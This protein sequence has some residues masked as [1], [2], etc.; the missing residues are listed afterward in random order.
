MLISVVIPVKNGDYWLEG[1]LEG[2]MGQTLFHRCEVILIDSGST[3]RTLEIVSRFPVRLVEIAPEQFNHG[4]TRNLGVQLAK[5][6]YVVMTVQDARAADE[7]WLQKLLDGFD[8]ADVAGVCGQQIVPHDPD[9]NPVV[10]FRPVDA[11]SVKKYRF[12]DPADFER[13]SPE[14]KRRVCSWDNVTAMYRREVLLKVPFRPAAF[15]EDAIWAKD[16]LLAGYAIVYNTAARVLHYH[17]DTPDFA[18]RRCFTTYY[19][20]HRIFGLRPSAADMGLIPLLRTMKLLLKAKSVPLKDK[21]KWLLYNYR[22]NR[23]INRSV[24]IFNKALGEGAKELD[25]VHADICRVPPQ[26]VKPSSVL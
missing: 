18:L 20:L 24:K 11:P 9:K 21:Y 6:E 16:A 10:W 4:S 15:A 23:A 3:D 8:T 7:G 5:G 14:E 1:V 22:W 2:L 26:A 12:Q 17:F 25:R 19:H 13:L